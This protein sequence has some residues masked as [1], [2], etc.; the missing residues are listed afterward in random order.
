M[1]S[2]NFSHEKVSEVYFAVIG[3]KV[4]TYSTKI[5]CELVQATGHLAKYSLTGE[6]SSFVMAFI[7]KILKEYSG[8]SSASDRAIVTLSIKVLHHFFESK[9]SQV[10]LEA[11]KIDLET[12]GGL[13]LLEKL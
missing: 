1:S 4:A 12:I 10:V 2:L 6:Q 3:Q 5:N 8:G 7:I 13:D 11:A 9:S